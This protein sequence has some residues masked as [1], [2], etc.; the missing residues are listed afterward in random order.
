[1]RHPGSED[2][3][4]Q[5]TGAEALQAGGTSPHQ[6]DDE[7]PLPVPGSKGSRWK[8]SRPSSAKAS[9]PGSEYQT[10]N[11]PAAAAVT[12][13]TEAPRDNES[14]ESEDTPRPAAAVE[15]RCKGSDSDP[16]FGQDQGSKD[17]AP[18]GR[19]KDKARRKQP[20]QSK[21]GASTIKSRSK[22]RASGKATPVRTLPASR[23]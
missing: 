6:S 14:T 9:I 5:S 18:T 22:S 3:E 12:P 7:V 16:D 2:E 4:A 8:R 17:E 11:G 15:R 13:K 10:S 23:Q 21:K 19:S 1:M 20:A